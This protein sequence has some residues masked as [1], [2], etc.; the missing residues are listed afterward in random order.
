MNNPTSKPDASNLDII[1]GSLDPT[2]THYLLFD[3][4]EDAEVAVDAYVVD[5]NESAHPNVAAVVLFPCYQGW[6][7]YL[8]APTD[9]LEGVPHE[10]VVRLAVAAYALRYQNLIAVLRLLPPDSR[11]AYTTVF[12]GR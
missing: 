7:A 5:L 4:G 10:E 6:P 2:A 11:A 3:D 1:S 12:E 8:Y 9:S